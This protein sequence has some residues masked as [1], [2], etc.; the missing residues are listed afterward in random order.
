M[1]VAIRS[2]LSDLLIDEAV[3][4]AERSRNAQVGRRGNKQ[5]LDNN[6]RYL[7]YHNF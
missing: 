4:N 6:S 2:A 3:N 1:I 5:W 7:V